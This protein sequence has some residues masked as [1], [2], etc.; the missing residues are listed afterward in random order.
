MNEVAIRDSTVRNRIIVHANG[1]T[2]EFTLAEL[3]LD[4]VPFSDLSKS[5]IIGT[6]NALSAETGIPLIP[7]NSYTWEP[8]AEN[9]SGSLFPKT[10]LG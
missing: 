3:T 10:Q 8:N 9:L 6:V 7:E 5:M 4:N 1:T 2:R